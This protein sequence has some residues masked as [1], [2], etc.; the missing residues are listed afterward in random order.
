MNKQS[1]TADKGWNPSLGVGQG[2]NNCLPYLT[3]LPNM[4]Q[5]LRLGLILS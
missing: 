2:A 3:V 5:D 1:Q 4:L